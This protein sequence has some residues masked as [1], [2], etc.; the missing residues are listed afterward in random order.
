MAVRTVGA[1]ATVTAEEIIALVAER[2]GSYKKPSRV[3]FTTEPLP[4]SVVGKLQRQVLREPYWAAH[5]CSVGG[6]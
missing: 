2:L 4:K 6:A 5:H 1:D 3:E